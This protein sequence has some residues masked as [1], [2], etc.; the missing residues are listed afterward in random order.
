[1]QIKNASFLRG[2]V[3]PKQYPEDGLPEIT[4][5]G[6]LMLANHRSLID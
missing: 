2:A 5:W 4:W 6:V 1:M 3:G